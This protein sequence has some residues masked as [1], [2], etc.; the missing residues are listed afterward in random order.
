MAMVAR[1]TWQLPPSAAE[2]FA[3]VSTKYLAPM[4][5]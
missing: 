1:R 4:L 2:S 3:L 5:A